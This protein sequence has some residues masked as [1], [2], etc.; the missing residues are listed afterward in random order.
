[1]N[2]KSVPG[3]VASLLNWIGG[4]L[5]S[6]ALLL[7]RL[8]WGFQLYE[9][10][11]GHLTHID[12]TA[13][14]FVKLNIPFPTASVYISGVTEWIGGILLM[15]GLFSRPISVLLFFNFCVVYMTASRA[16]VVKLLHFQNPD[17]FINADAFPFLVTSLLI[18]AFGPGKIALD[19]LLSRRS[20]AGR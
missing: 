12:K 13:Q 1:M 19:C 16:S 3:R 11:W 2:L 18:L 7:I 5:Q 8:A 15:L 17:D 9:S 20:A 4:W 10:G 14:F 6:P